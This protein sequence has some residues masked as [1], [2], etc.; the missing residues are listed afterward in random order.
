MT[1]RRY[2][3]YYTCPEGPLADMAAAWLGWDAANLEEK[4]HPELG[5]NAAEITERPRKYGFHATLKA[6]FRTADG[7]SAGLLSGALR[8]FAQ[9]QTPVT[10]D[11]L[12]VATLGSFIA[13]VPAVRSDELDDLAASC[14]TQFDGFRAPLTADELTRRKRTRLTASQEALLDSWGYPYVLEEFRFHMTLTGPL[15]EP[16]PVATILRAHFAAVLPSPFVIDAVSICGER[17]DG[18]FEV[19]ER[20]PLKG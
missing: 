9:G 13:L 3:L 8:E 11:G 4:P 10:L 16:E 7:V 19:I 17:E 18:R 1:H 5:L 14:V 12:R 2:A 6:P 20:V 15:P